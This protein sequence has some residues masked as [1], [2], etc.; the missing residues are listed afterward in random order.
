MPELPPELKPK[1]EKLFINSD[2]H[3]SELRIE[4]SK[5]SGGSHWYVDGVLKTPE[6][7]RDWLSYMKTF[8]YQDSS[9]Y[10]QLYN[11]WTDSQEKDFLPIPTSL[12]PDYTA[13]AGIGMDRIAYMMRKYP[14]EVADLFLGWAKVAV[15]MQTRLFEAGI[16]MVFFCD[17]HCY[18]DRCMINPQ[19]FEQFI[20]PAMKLMADNAHKHGAKI[21]LH[22]DGYLVEEMPLVIKAGIDAAEPLEYEA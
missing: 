18:K 3:A 16:D 17:D 10:T 22:S 21:F 4:N 19:Q 1:F 2:G 20:Y 13:W 8:E 11:V 9:Y 7:I 12:G 6:L 15:E 5:T 14:T